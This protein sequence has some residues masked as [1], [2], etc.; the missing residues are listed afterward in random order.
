MEKRCYM[1]VPFKKKDEVKQ[2]SAKWDMEL[3]L[4][5]FK[6]EIPEQFKKY[7]LVEVN[8]KYNKKEYYKETYKSLCWSPNYHSWI[9]NYKDFSSMIDNGDQ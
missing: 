9:C 6:N 1:V 5:Y 8:I 2:A 4:W 3:K 7:E